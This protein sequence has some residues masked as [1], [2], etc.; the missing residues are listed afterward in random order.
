[1]RSYCQQYLEL[2]A[3]QDNVDHHEAGLC[4]GYISSKIELMSYSQQMCQRETLN[5]DQIISHFV[6]AA[7]HAD[8]QSQPAIVIVMDVLEQHHGCGS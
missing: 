2:I 1:M 3:L 5:V 6:I 7:G 4:N 8:A